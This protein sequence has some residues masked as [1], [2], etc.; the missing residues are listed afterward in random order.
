M[1]SMIFP[2]ILLFVSIGTIRSIP[3]TVPSDVETHTFRWITKYD[4]NNT[5]CA[6]A[7]KPAR[8]PNDTLHPDPNWSFLH[9]CKD[10]LILRNLKSRLYLGLIL[11]SV[12]STPE[13]D[14]MRC[15]NKNSLFTLIGNPGM[16]W[17][18]LSGQCVH[19]KMV[20]YTAGGSYFDGSSERIYFAY[21]S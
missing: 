16:L 14:R 5:K 10:A 4:L 17:H 1:N 2:V 8:L 3:L 9:G 12:A 11:M 6:Y 18:Q 21:V 20:N 13:D 7:S 15:Q 19:T